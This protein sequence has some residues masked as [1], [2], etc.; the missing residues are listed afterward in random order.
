MGK[1]SKRDDSQE[2]VPKHRFRFFGRIY[3]DESP[4]DF[5]VT[6][7]HL[8]FAEFAAL[9]RSEGTAGAAARSWYRWCKSH[10][11]KWNPSHSF[12]ALVVY[13]E[14]FLEPLQTHCRE[15]KFWSASDDSDR[16]EPRPNNRKNRSD[17]ARNRFL[18][19]I[20]RDLES[21]KV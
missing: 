12:F 9:Y 10:S 13:I 18:D 6:Y 1:Q 20:I 19:S 8:N 14:Q 21:L 11:K 5:G 2:K 16:E 3:C 15:D 17:A 7:N 4:I